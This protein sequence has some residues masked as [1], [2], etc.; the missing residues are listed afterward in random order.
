M[1]VWL[2]GWLADQV[3]ETPGAWPSWLLQN[4]GPA[5]CCLLP[6]LPGRPAA[7]PPGHPATRPPSHPTAC[8]SRRLV[9][10]LRRGLVRLS[11]R[12][13]CRPA[14]TQAACLRAT[15]SHAQTRLPRPKDDC[16]D[17]LRQREVLPSLL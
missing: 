11:A 7:W 15:C 12:L 3:T 8:P 14:C 4:L 6:S 10:S 16:P 2:A 17:H 9:V 1:A 5:S 13:V